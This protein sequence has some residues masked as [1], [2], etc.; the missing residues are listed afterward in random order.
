MTNSKNC[1][2]AVTK[3]NYALF[4]DFHTSTGIP[5]VGEK[6]DVEKF[7]DNLKACGVDFITW[8]AR[9]NQ[10][11]AYYFTKFGYKHP[12]LK[13]D[14]LREIGESCHRKGIRVSAYFNGGLSDEE[15]LHNREWMRIAPDGRS[16]MPPERR[17]SVENRV[18]CYNSAYREHLKNMVRE[19]AE[20][21]PVD[22]FFFDCMCSCYTCVCD[23]CVTEMK[24]KQID[25]TDEQ[26][27]V[28]FAKYSIIRLVKELYATIKEIKPEALF[29]LNGA[30]V[31][32]F[33]GYDTHLECECLP[34]CKEL[35]Y[36]YLPVQA[37]NLRTVAQGNPVL[38]MTARFYNWGDFGG[39]RKA[40]SI[41]YDLFYA[42]ANGMR[43]DV[44]GH[45]HPRGDMDQVVFDLLKQ[46]YTNLQ[47]YDKW[48]LDA[49]N[50]P[51]I[52][53][54]FPKSGDEL[55]TSVSLK[56]AVRML[57]ELKYQIDVVTE[58][59]SWDHYS[60]LVFPDTVTFSEETR[61]R[62]ER[63]IAKG[64]GVIASGDSG[65]SPDMKE[66]VIRDWPVR[67]LGKT[68]ADPLYFM[69]QGHFAEEIP[70]MPLSV[71]AS[72]T[73]T[74]PTEGATVEMFNVKPYFNKGFDG[75]RTSWYC[76]PEKPTDEPFLAIKSRIAYF[77]GK[78]F[79]GYFNRGAYQLRYLLGNVMRS[80]LPEPLLRSETLPSYARAF[81]QK[82]EHMHLLHVMAYT[83]ELR[84]DNVALEER[85]VLIDTHLAVRTNGQTIKKVYTAPDG[86]ELSFV[87]DG[88]YCKTTLPLLHG[89]ALIV[90]E[91]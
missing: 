64:G 52:G 40:E 13:F 35:G 67:Y 12:S 23:R 90:F 47:R 17:V 4:Y 36:D 91:E 71:Y 53:I 5:D 22:G 29:F 42:I 21:Y 44:G 15:L 49:V 50:H 3:I 6:F 1:G 20:D 46:V 7:T 77:S 75:I 9:C 65:L 63:H 2:T 27:I 59:A 45:F 39:L 14:M 24:E 62:I 16:F 56:A 51:E 74:C 48:T 82:K 37:H 57:T 66:F 58:A 33:I 84:G 38:A 81:V 61:K 10:G 89:Y 8:A 87:M 19:L 18:V 72:G 26:Q 34:P 43:P 79:E 78:I 85:A 32:E 30:M 31:D 54:V 86:K 11:N 25:Y 69:P 28:Q 41:E 76:P 88:N 73:K 60:V 68:Q 80:L 83:P 55:R 70:V